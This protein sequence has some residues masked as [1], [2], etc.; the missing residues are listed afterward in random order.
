[1]RHQD[2]CRRSSTLLHLLL[3]VVFPVC[4]TQTHRCKAS[5]LCPR[6]PA[7]NDAAALRLPACFFLSSLPP[8][9]PP[10]PVHLCPVSSSQGPGRLAGP[11]PAAAAGRLRGGARPA[12]RRHVPPGG[13][14]HG[15]P[16]GGGGAAAGLQ[17]HGTGVRGGV[18]WVGMGPLLAP[19]GV[20]L[21]NRGCGQAHHG[22]CRGR[23]AAWPRLPFRLLLLCRR[24]T[25]Y[26]PFH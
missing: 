9:R 8:S 21:S 16:G 10:S 20:I 1:M 15:L 26:V 17:L 24:L 23:V 5:P 22:A 6:S 2:L 14:R 13:A 18:G 4:P 19:A 12:R 11:L 3:F 25:F 7:S